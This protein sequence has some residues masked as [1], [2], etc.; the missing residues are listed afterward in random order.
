MGWVDKEKCK[1]T[2]KG[3]KTWK[4]PGGVG[5]MRT[6]V[7]RD[8]LGAPRDPTGIDE[9]GKWRGTCKGVPSDLVGGIWTKWRSEGE[10][11]KGAWKYGLGWMD[12]AGGWTGQ[13]GG[14][15]DL[16]ETPET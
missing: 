2:Y 3:A 4:I 9:E 13:E 12:R 5:S 10:G 16:E 8:L 1:G 6:E 11:A 7:A 14:G 15:G